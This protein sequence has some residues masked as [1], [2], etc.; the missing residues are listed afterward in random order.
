MPEDCSWGIQLNMQR[1]TRAS[2]TWRMSPR[3]G[4]P[5]SSQTRLQSGLQPT[6]RRVRTVIASPEKAAWWWA[7]QFLCWISDANQ[8]VTQTIASDRAGIGPDTD[9]PIEPCEDRDMV[10]AV[11]RRRRSPETTRQSLSSL[12]PSPWR[13]TAACGHRIRPE[14]L[15]SYTGGF[16]VSSSF[17]LRCEFE[18]CK[19]G[20]DR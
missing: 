2:R 7:G 15:S 17:I 3:L 1:H 12:E 4:L 18:A 13:M 19:L 11:A 8:G 14:G 16:S 5:K 10:A 9:R 20:V 6:Y